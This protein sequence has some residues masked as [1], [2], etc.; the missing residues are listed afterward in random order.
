MK[1][2]HQNEGKIREILGS[3]RVGILDV[4][5]DYGDEHAAELSGKIDQ[6][7][8]AI[9]DEM[10]RICLLAKPKPLD[11]VRERREAHSLAI[12]EFVVNLKAALAKE[13]GES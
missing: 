12:R 1:T 4:Y 8:N 3:L 7:L 10:E 13:R 5:C 2:P 6:A 9:C 11:D